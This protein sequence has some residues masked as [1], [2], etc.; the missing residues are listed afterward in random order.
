MTND[1]YSCGKITLVAVLL[2]NSGLNMCRVF[3]QF[4]ETVIYYAPNGGW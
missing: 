2:L 1:I 4:C 3:G